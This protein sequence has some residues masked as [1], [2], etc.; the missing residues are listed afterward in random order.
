MHIATTLLVLLLPFTY[1]QYG[2]PSPSAAASTSSAAS[3]T[4]SN[5]HVVS[6]GSNGLV[7]TPNTITAPVGDQVE[8]H[9]F[10]PEHSVAQSTFSS[11]CAPPSNGTGFWS[12]FIQT[13]SNSNV[14][15]FSHPFAATAP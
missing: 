10:P 15:Y 14:R 7:F 11:P 5:V 8:F 6:V 2:A 12:G 4:P 13:S 1:G 9:F 3:S